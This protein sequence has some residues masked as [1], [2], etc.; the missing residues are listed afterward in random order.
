[1]KG[2]ALTIG[3]I[4]L[5]LLVI[6]LLGEQ[7]ERADE[8]AHPERTAAAIDVAKEAIRRA[9][10]QMLANVDTSDTKA[11]KYSIALYLLS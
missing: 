7:W 11:N 10:P 3:V 9:Q 2:C 8:Q 1:M 6:G 5:V 4:V